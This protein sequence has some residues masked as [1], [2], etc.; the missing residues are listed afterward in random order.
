M[1]RKPSLTP[2]KDLNTCLKDNIL[3]YIALDTEFTRRTTYWPILELVQLKTPF[4][5]CLVDAAQ[6]DF[7]ASI[8]VEKFKDPATLFLVH[9]GRQDIEIFFHKIK[10][11][12]ENLFDT[13][14]AAC[15][16]GYGESC[17]YSDLVEKLLGVVLDKSLQ[18]KTWQIRP[19]TPSQLSYA[20]DDVRY[21][22][23]LYEILYKELVEKNRLELFKEL[24]E[25]FYDPSSL[26]QDQNT[27]WERFLPSFK[28]QGL[29][30]KQHLKRFKALM[31]LRE[32]IAQEENLLRKNVL[33]DL[34]ILKICRMKVFSLEEIESI[35]ER[36]SDSEALPPASPVPPPASPAKE[37]AFKN[38]SAKSGNTLAQQIFNA[39]E[40]LPKLTKSKPSGPIP[41]DLASEQ[42]EAFT[43][44]STELSV[45]AKNLNIPK[46]WLAA[47]P[48]LIQAALWLLDF[49]KELPK[50]WVFS[51]MD[52]KKMK[53]DFHLKATDE[54]K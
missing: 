38:E 54:P 30:V 7:D 42:Q 16:C 33:S 44:I 21:L 9:S 20:L 45:V 8:F 51:Y 32:E 24:M 48:D 26:I 39:F 35:L 23:P 19:F 18:N 17:S 10:V 2:F 27:V 49:D 22:Y 14:I 46:K 47:N 11:L 13:Q 53:D 15:V 31:K 4:G 43:F 29:R 3:R 37:E 34:A 6:E 41:Q 40:S 52:L 5:Y 28:T 1:S 50:R 12:P 25:K 36:F